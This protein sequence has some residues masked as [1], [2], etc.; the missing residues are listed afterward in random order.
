MDKLTELRA[1][2]EEGE[3]EWE[4]LHV[5]LNKVARVRAEQGDAQAFRLMQQQA[6]A[7]GIRR[8]ELRMKMGLS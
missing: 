7:V 6:M 2:E 3:R 5:A 4:W 8:I 1:R